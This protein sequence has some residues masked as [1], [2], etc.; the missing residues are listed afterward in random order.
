[1]KVI[2]DEGVPKQLASNLPGH[3]VTTVQDQGWASVKNGKLLALIAENRFEAFLSCD[4]N[5]EFQQ[6]LGHRPF[7]ILLLS[8]NHWPSMKPHIGKITDELDASEPGT[9]RQVTCGI[10]QKRRRPFAPSV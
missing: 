3:S 4:R 8:T 5:L 1:M 6:T 2:L 10:F 7:A 9:V